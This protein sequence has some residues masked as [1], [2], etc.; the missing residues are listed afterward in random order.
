MYARIARFEGGSGSAI[1][2]EIDRIHQEIRS[3]SREQTGGYLPDELRRRVSR[4]ETLVDRQKGSVALIVYCETEADIREAD[5]I[6]DSMSPRNT[7]WG[8]R[9]SS[10]IYEVS[11]DQ[12]MELPRAA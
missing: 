4:I 8:R 10:D 3:G 12:S 11:L 5:R 2:E 1:D 7:E 9:V 6:L